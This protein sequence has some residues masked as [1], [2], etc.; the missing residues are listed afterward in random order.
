MSSTLFTDSSSGVVVAFGEVLVRLSSGH[1]RLRDANYLQIDVGGS[2]LNVLTALSQLGHP[3]RWVTAVAG[4]ELGQRVIEHAS[5]FGVDVRATTVRHARTPLYFAE[6]GSPPRPT[7]ITYDRGGSAFTVESAVTCDWR[8]QLADARWFHS[9]GITLALSP[10][11]CAATTAAYETARCAA[12]PTSFDLN[13]RDQLWSWSEALPHYQQVLST[14]Q[15]LFASTPDLQKLTRTTKEDYDLMDTAR[16]Q[17]GLRGI[18]LRTTEP[19]S[20]G[21]VTVHTSVGIDGA[22]A[23][24][25]RYVAVPVDPVGSGDAATAAVL[26]AG[27][28]GEELAVIAERASWACAD[29]LTMPGDTWWTA[30]FTGAPSASSRL[31]VR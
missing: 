17:F 1:R 24:S 4:D 9:S 16:R 28:A 10:H 23:T 2:E 7:S 27:L 13:H 11:A 26:A 31:V 12:I 22:Y 19:T 15:L 3:G 18:V 8:T 5:K 29:K 25:N 21:T 20:G 14:T 30:S 6:L